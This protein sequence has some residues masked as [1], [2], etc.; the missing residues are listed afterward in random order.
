[1]KSHGF[2]MEISLDVVEERENCK[3]TDPEVT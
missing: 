1:M 3:N 2:L